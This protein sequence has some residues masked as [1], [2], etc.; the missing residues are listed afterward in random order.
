M[1]K[2]LESNM[3]NIEFVEFIC[4]V[5]KKQRRAKKSVFEERKNKCNYCLAKESRKQTCLEKYGTTSTFKSKD[6]QEKIKQTNLKRYGNI[7]PISTKDVQ[8]R[9]K[10]TCLE[11]YGVSHP[12]ASEDVKQA[13]KNKL[14]E[15]YNVDNV[16]QLESVKD[17]KK[18]TS[19]EHF[20]AEHHLQSPEFVNEYRNVNNE[21]FGVDFP[22][23]KPEAI[24]KR[25]QTCL[26]K[27]GSENPSTSEI[28]KKRKEATCLEHYGVKYYA[29]SKE[30]S[31]NRRQLYNYDGQNFDSK[32]ELAFYIWCKDHGKNIS[33]NVEGIKYTVPEDD[34][35]HYYFPDFNV[36]GELYEIKGN[37]FLT[38][39]GTWQNPFDSTSDTLYEAKHK[40]AIDN[41]VKIL[42]GNDYRFYIDYVDRTYT[43][44]FLNLFKLNLPFPYV[45]ADF[46]NKTDLGILQYFHKSIYDANKFNKPSPRQAWEDK[47][48][49]RK[50]ALNRL[51]YV[52][53]CT[54]NDIRQGFSVTRLAPK[55]SIFRPKLA[56]DLIKKYLNDF[57]E[58]VDPFSGFSGR[59]L[60]AVNCHKRYFGRDIH[61]DHV[62]ES[63]E[64]LA[65]KN[66]NTDDYCIIV[67]DLLKKQNTES[68]ECLF[69]CP[70]YGA[71]EHW[72]KDNDEIEKTCD[73]WIDICLSKYNCKRY[74][75]VVDETEKY[76]DKVVEN[77][78]SKQ[79]LFKK[80]NEKVLLFER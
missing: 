46:S 27:Y 9:R 6:V 34:R 16:S 59:L 70:P 31:K 53:S 64:I 25:K 38:K 39:E 48:L 17:K 45:N 1:E 43:K 77:L 54:P 8:K 23:L 67:E 3:S 76:K 55:I 80:L 60:G 58:I 37:Q 26:E 5:C 15:T 35:E 7:S 20:G 32:P 40:C 72:N 14:L 18:Q 78:T 29:Q 50:V 73:E 61:P 19:L 13:R 63:N 69:T 28:V 11:K 62:K 79:G 49:V 24:V 2:E 56:E 75:F 57:S 30:A 21:K 10:Q 51:K 42:Y 12:W 22:F 4:P 65:Y 66:L 47:E 68:F 52:K 33:R 41:G 71:K 36:D 74:L 44:D